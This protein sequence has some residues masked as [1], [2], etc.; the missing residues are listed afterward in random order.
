LLALR[1]GSAMPQLRPMTADFEKHD[2]IT[3]RMNIAA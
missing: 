2:G 3:N 1:L